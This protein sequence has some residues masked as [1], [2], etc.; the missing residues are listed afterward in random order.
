MQ[1]KKL[2]CV[3]GLPWMPCLGGIHLA[4][5][6]F[7]FRIEFGGC[8]V[9]CV[10]FR[11]FNLIATLHSPLMQNQIPRYGH[12]LWSGLPIATVIVCG[13]NEFII[14]GAV[15]GQPISVSTLP[16]PFADQTVQ[17]PAPC[18]PR[19]FATHSETTSG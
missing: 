6:I 2:F 8:V 15:T 1:G 12:S 16:G 14:D 13:L 19:A 17:N 3:K 4:E 7:E 9:A 10:A 18:H 11:F 5:P